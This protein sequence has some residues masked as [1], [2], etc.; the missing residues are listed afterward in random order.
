VTSPT[1]D[2]IT[3][4]P[5]KSLDGVDVEEACVLPSGGLEFDRRWRLRVPCGWRC[6]SV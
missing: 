5:V 2:R 1:L 6:C 3:L 4:Y